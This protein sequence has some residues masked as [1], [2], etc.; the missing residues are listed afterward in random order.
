MRT[1][2]V[3]RLRCPDCRGP[4]LRVGEST[5][6]CGG[7]GATFPM[8]A[9]RP[10]L[11]RS[12]ND[13]F[14]RALYHP[15]PLRSVARKQSLAFLVPSRSVNLA[16]RRN[17]RAFASLFEK[18]AGKSV[19]VVGAGSQ[20]D[21]LED[22]FGSRA[23]VE[24]T[25]CD[26]D[27]NGKVDLFCDGHELPFLDESFDGAIACA[28]LEHVAHP[29][30][31][32]SEMHRVLRPAGLVYTEI[33]FLQ[34]VHEGA[35]DFTRYTLSG[36]RRLLNRFQ[37]IR[38]GVVAGPGTTLA[39][40]VEHF[41]VCCA[42]GRWLQTGA[43]VLVRTALFWLKYADYLFGDSGAAADGASCTFFLGRR[44]STTR[45]DHEIVAEYVGVKVLRH[46]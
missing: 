37:E 26:V 39:W 21:W 33:P 25:Y 32:V 27:I 42:P 8:V 15:T 34:Q 18:D 22:F 9:G 43:R 23:D 20:R 13:L 5:A 19:L 46:V 10:V 24:L 16:Y 36:H 40:A 14:P 44:T 31:V 41:A 35:Y 28:V 6:L 3:T 4:D 38:S 11:I 1:S 12:D 7:C 17:L 29:E 45:P 2:L 30:R